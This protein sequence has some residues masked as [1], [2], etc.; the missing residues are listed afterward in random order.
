MVGT[1]QN[2]LIRG[3][4][5]VVVA[6]D[7][8]SKTPAGNPKRVWKDIGPVA[9]WKALGKAALIRKVHTTVEAIRTGKSLDGPETFEVVF[10]DFMKRHVEKNGLITVPPSSRIALIGMRRARRARFE[11]PSVRWPPRPRRGS[12]TT[13]SPASC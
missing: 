11:D 4:S 1:M 7:P 8:N 13:P 10:A 5:Y 3:S 6:T 12:R 9:D 2:L